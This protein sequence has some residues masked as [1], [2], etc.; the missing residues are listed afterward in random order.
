MLPGP[1]LVVE[2]REAWDLARA[3]D[4]LR[5][6]QERNG[7]GRLPESVVRCHAQLRALG[8]VYERGEDRPS[9][10]GVSASVREEGVPAAW[11][12]D[13]VDTAEA[14]R[15]LGCG[16]HNIR[17]LRRRGALHG[18]RVGRSWWFDRGEVLE[19][20][21]ARRVPAGDGSRA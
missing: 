9:D 17:D 16:A 2:P 10:V 7:G 6:V 21:D 1:C 12:R 18:E 14:G 4:L 3:L 20:R 5:R 15:I 19:L 11:D 8:E 13:L